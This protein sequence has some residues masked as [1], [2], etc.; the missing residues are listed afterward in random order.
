MRFVTSTTTTTNPTLFSVNINSH[1]PIFYTHAGT[2]ELLSGYKKEFAFF[3]KWQR[4]N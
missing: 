2:I 4:N 3:W 1:P